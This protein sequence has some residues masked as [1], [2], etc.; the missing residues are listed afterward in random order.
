[1]L[2]ICMLFFSM[3]TFAQHHHH[4]DTTRT[5]TQKKQLN[6]S[7]KN[8]K[9]SA[10]AKKDTTTS[11]QQSTSTHTHVLDDSTVIVHDKNHN[12][13]KT[14]TGHHQ[15]SM[16]TTDTSAVMTHHHSMN[17]DSTHGIHTEHNNM[18]HA[19]S[20]NLPM[21]RNGS[22]TAWLPDASPMFGYMFHSQKWMYMLHGNIFIR[23]NNQDFTNKGSR[24]DAMVDAP[25]WMMF[26]GQRKVGRNG[27][28]H[29]NTMFSLDEAIAGGKG[30]PLLFQSGELYKGQPLVDRQHP[31]DLFSELSVSYSQALSKNFDVF[32]YLA[33]PG[34]PALGPVAF[35]HRPSAL[36]N[37]DAP[38]SHHWIDATHITFGVA[39]LG[40]RAGQFKLEASSFTG[41]EP[42]ENRY[43]FD[44]PRFD[45]WSGRISFNPSE[46]WALQISQ[47]FLKSPETLHPGEDI[48]RTTASA[49]YSTT[50]QKGS[51]N[52]TAAWGMNKRKQH[53]GENAFL[54][55]ASWNKKRLT[56]HTR[57]EYV[58]KSAE[59]LVLDETVY[60]HDAVFN[61]NAF[62]LGFDYDLFNIGKT[63]LAAGSHL[64]WFSAD[65]RLDNLY[66]NNPMAVEVYLRIYPSLM[67]TK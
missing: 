20:T 8:A 61:I 17:N 10:I 40:I 27:L 12:E 1:M 28:F 30:Y 52:A 35:M 44:K 33:Y 39:T 54:A 37:P 45:S 24:G 26:M 31:H 46:K 60:G 55:E 64:T 57:Y 59:E 56:L 34:E 51:L 2:W 38:V 18:S 63:K 14:D 49:I 6:R 32:A 50:L 3:A 58:Q 16:N 62:T 9:K 41:R 22:G 21:N 43:N 47:A 25:N 65:K 4:T 29:F 66:G 53:D 13:I 7:K 19:F 5:V 36:A 15:H 11:K 23:Y 67:M 48:T 42:D